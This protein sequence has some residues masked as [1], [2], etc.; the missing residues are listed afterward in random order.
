[1][2]RSPQM[3]FDLAPP[4]ES[5]DDVHPAL[6]AFHPIIQ[7][8]FRERVGLPSEPQQRGWPLIRGGRNVLIAAPTGSGKTLSAFLACLDALFRESLQGTLSDV[9]RVLYV[10][11]LKALG[12]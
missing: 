5:D 7:R 12:N 8:W 2:T 1:M 9:T 6:D 3:R 11:P 10:S 4:I